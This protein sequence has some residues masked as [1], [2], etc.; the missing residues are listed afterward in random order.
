MN[1]R[2]KLAKKAE[3]GYILTL[4]P[5]LGSLKTPDNQKA[6][7]FLNRLDVFAVNFHNPPHYRPD[8]CYMGYE[9]S[10]VFKVWKPVWTLKTP[11]TVY[12]SILG[13]GSKVN[14][15]SVNTKKE[16]P[17]ICEVVLL[18]M[19]Y[20]ANYF[21]CFHA[22]PPYKEIIYFETFPTNFLHLWLNISVWVISLHVY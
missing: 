19:L 9:I 10:Y 16:M 22:E 6:S 4:K 17:V 15:R 14:M 5:Y 11:N 1:F 12:V 21:Q 18:S 20:H 2:E 7:Y 8:V 3:L 13:N